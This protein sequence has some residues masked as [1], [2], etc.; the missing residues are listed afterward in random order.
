MERCAALCQRSPSILSP[1]AQ[2]VITYIVPEIGE[3][4][5]SEQPS[6]LVSEGTTGLRTWEAS[7]LLS[8]W[9]L[10]QDL[11]GKNILELGSGTG[12]ASIIA[13]K[14]GA[15]VLATDGSEIVVSRLRSNFELNCVNADTSNLWWGEPDEILE[16]KWD[17]IIGAD[18]T[19]DDEI[20]STLSQTFALGLPNG[21]IG[22]LAVTVRNEKT[23]NTFMKESGISFMV[24]LNT[25]ISWFACTRDSRSRSE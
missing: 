11:K 1:T 7:F 24:C 16:R 3:I 17:Y 9:L 8:E 19:Y 12:L 6:L 4:Y 20:C 5:I 25:S 10:G 22:I 14:K 13:S 23:L 15:N 2:V 18:I 21:G